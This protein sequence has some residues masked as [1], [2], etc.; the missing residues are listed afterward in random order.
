VVIMTATRGDRIL[1]G[2]QAHFQPGMY[3]TLAGFMEPGETLEDA[4]RRE[5]LGGI[6][7]HCRARFTT[8]PASLGRSHPA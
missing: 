5:I 2:R 6:R 7:H 8:I 3:S 1:L 4:V